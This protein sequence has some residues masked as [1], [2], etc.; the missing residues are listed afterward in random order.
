[1]FFLPANIR[2]YFE[3]AKADGGF[4]LWLCKKLCG[5][6]HTA[7]VGA[8]PVPARMP[9][10]AF[11][12]RRP[13]CTLAPMG[14]RAGTGPAPT[15]AVSPTR[16]F[17]APL[18]VK[19]RRQGRCPATDSLEWRGFEI[20]ILRRTNSWQAKRHPAG[21][22]AANPLERRYLGGRITNPTERE[23]GCERGL[24]ILPKKL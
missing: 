15:L 6:R 17:A 23:T 11:I 12:R 19:E 24:L 22:R 3:C 5:V 1:M 8:G 2:N 7:D 16:N 9:D 20:L 21:C 18:F 10:R 14:H 4:F 13:P